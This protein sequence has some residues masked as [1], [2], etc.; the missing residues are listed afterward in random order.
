MDLSLKKSSKKNNSKEYNFKERFRIL[1][2][3][4]SLLALALLIFVPLI[5]FRNNIY[6][7]SIRINKLYNEYL[8]LKEEN[9]VLKAK[10]EK[11]RFNNQVEEILLYKRLESDKIR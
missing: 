6:Y 9:K 2:Y 11:I 4:L 7:T 8:L 1:K 5:H 3:M 10:L